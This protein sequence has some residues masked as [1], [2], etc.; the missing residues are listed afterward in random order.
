VT[1]F[2]QTGLTTATATI[3]ITTD[4]TGPFS[5]TVSWLSGEIRQF[6]PDGAAQTFQRSGA[7]TYTLTVVHTFQ[8]KGCYWAVRAA[9]TPASADGGA[10]QQ[11]LTGQCEIR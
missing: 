4:G 11:L 5:L 7:G 10:S 3:Q 6:A 1:G 2:R 9:T 8:G